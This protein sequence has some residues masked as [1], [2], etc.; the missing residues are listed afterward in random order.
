VATPPP[1][2]EVILTPVPGAVCVQHPSVTAVYTCQNCCSD[3]CETC[4]FPQP[5]G[6]HLCPNCASRQATVPPLISAPPVIT[7]APVIPQGV[8]CVQHPNLPATAKCQACG[9]FMCQTCTFDLPGGMKICP[10][11]ATAT[12]KLSPK[13]KKFLIGSY[14]FAVWCTVVMAALFGGAFRDFAHDKASEELFG[15]LL[16]FLLPIPSL[17]GVALGVS[18]MDRRL[19]NSI[20]MWIA[21]AWNGLILAGFILLIIVGLAKGV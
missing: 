6:S 20:G 2:S 17:I 13:R 4:N 3:I 12:P 14:V 21:T 11:C 16:M 8:R 9:G 1:S 15:M 19:P 7:N 10:T 18:A 5:D